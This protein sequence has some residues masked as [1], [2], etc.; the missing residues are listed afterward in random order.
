MPNLFYL[1]DR[2]ARFAA[3][4]IIFTKTLPNDH[5]G[6]ILEDQM[7]RSALSSALNYGEAQGTETDKDF[8]HKMS[9]VVK[10]LKETRVALKVVFFVQYGNDAVLPNLQ[11]ECGE[12][13]AICATRIKNRKKTG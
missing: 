6:K 7:M 3:D 2:L 4:I 11:K 8:V 1:E 9:I 10:E 13:V 5:G 12:L